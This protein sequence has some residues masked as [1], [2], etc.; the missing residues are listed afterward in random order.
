MVP[1]T[2]T[3]GKMSTVVK[4]GSYAFTVL[5]CT[6][7]IAMGIL[8]HS[9]QADDIKE[10]KENDEKIE[11]TVKENHKEVMKMLTKIEIQLASKDKSQ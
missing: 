11:K 10:C 2:T 9:I 3:N 7:I 6:F 1:P 5:A 8:L 4:L